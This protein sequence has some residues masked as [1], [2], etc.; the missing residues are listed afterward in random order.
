M[1]VEQTCRREGYRRSWPHRLTLVCFIVS[2]STRRHKRPPKCKRAVARRPRIA[3]TN[4]ADEYPFEGKVKVKEEDLYGKG[5]S[6]PDGPLHDGTSAFYS[7][8]GDISIS[9]ALLKL[10][11]LFVRFV[12]MEDFVS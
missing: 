7:H 9:T 5:I 1:L 8:R 3:P 6:Y 4:A 11:Y 10:K 2:N 12:P